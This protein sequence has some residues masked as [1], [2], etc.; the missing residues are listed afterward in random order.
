[1]GWQDR[2]KE[3]QARRAMA[4]GVFQAKDRFGRVLVPGDL[5]VY[6]PQVDLVYEI[7]AVQ[8]NLDPNP[9]VTAQGPTLLLVLGT[10]IPLVVRVGQPMMNMIWV[11]HREPQPME[12]PFDGAT[13]KVENP[14]P[15]PG[16]GGPSAPPP[17]PDLG[18][19]HDDGA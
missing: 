9:A 10:Q 5:I 15:G 6:R 13:G 18:N 11:D 4:D 3:H 19:S 14:D 16:P 7:Q 12:P 2:I 8:P 17:G 1:M